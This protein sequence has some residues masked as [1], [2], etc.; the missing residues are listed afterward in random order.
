[1]GVEGDA[2]VI[3]EGV[4]QSGCVHAGE[5]EEAEGERSGAAAVDGGH[6]FGEDGAEVGLG[7]FEGADARGG[8]N[9]LGEAGADSFGCHG[10][11]IACAGDEGEEVFEGVE[12]TYKGIVN[13]LKWKDRGILKVP[14]VYEIGDVLQTS[15]VLKAEE[16]GKN[17]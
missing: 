12:G 3:S 10:T 6:G 4:A 17:I 8:G 11:V 1:M 15:Y 14:S 16:M 13:Y 5:T 7:A 9:P 2:G